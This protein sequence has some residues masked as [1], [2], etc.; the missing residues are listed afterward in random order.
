MTI[1]E[2]KCLEKVCIDCNSHVIDGGKLYCNVNNR[3]K[4]EESKMEFF[5]GP[6]KEEKK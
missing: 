4:Q 1:Q 3:L 6:A 5:G 2:K